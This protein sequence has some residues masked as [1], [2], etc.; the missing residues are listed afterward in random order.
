MFIFYDFLLI[1][2][3]IINQTFNYINTYNSYISD[4]V[5]NKYRQVIEKSLPKCIYNQNNIKEYY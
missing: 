3:Y 2:K 5:K 1:M 4:M